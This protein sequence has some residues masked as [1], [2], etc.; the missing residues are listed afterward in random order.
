MSLQ[1]L[2]YFYDPVGNITSI[3]DANGHVTQFAYDAANHLTV[4]SYFDGTTVGYAYD[5][6]GNRTSMT[7]YRGTTSYIYDALNRVSGVAQ[8]GGATVA[9]SYD[10]VGHRVGVNYPDNKAV[11]Y[12]YDAANRLRN[13]TDW[14]NR[15]TAYS[16][17]PANRLLGV[18]Y[19]NT[20]SISFAYD[21]ANRL[22]NVRNTYPASA[23]GS[24][25]QF[26]SFTYAL[27]KV[28]NRTS[29]TD[30]N[31]TTT[32]YTFDPRYEL[33]S[34]T[35][36]LGSTNYT[37]DA[38]GNRL[39][40]SVP[41]GSVTSYKYDA[42]DRLLSAGKTSFTYDKNGNRVS[43]K[44]PGQTLTYAYD[45]ANRL[46]S[47]AGGSQPSTFAYDGDGHRV[48]QTIPS[49]TYT[50]VNDTISSLPVVLQE[51]GPDGFI[52]YAYGLGLISESSS[53]FDY[54][55]HVDGLGSTVGLTD[56]AGS[57]QQGY[58]YDAWGNIG[59]PAPNY[60]GTANKFRYTGQALD[61]GSFL[62]YLRARYL[63]QG[64]G[65]F[66][67]NDPIAHSARF[68]LAANRY[69]YALSN[70]VRYADATGLGWFDTVLDLSL[71]Y[72]TGQ[73]ALSDYQSEVQCALNT[74]TGC[75]LNDTSVNDTNQEQV[76]AL[77]YVRSGG[78]EA[79]ESIYNGT[80]VIGPG[81][82][83]TAFDLVVSALNANL[84]LK[85]ISSIPGKLIDLFTP[86]VA[87]AADLQT[88]D[89]SSAPS[90]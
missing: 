18:N 40:L 28:G 39:T 68:P 70:P 62:Y 79:G 55:Y 74:G 72:K 45:A 81:R 36:V 82:A 19:P 48:S 16:F 25:G 83:S 22:T 49:G 5:P 41:G 59:A 38:F 61:P 6:D 69:A 80:N 64:I 88:V 73:Q 75:T 15:T 30:G 56:S 17:D 66:I 26:T 34:A 63:E 29:V 4:V 67:N 77:N 9:Y 33:T 47:V 90:K 76:K 84:L 14:Q 58:T 24:T 86:G 60:V 1:D 53:A 65:R 32:S 12:S 71:G 54:F 52:S 42:D 46:V 20:A 7:D 57:L 21:S 51:N 31:G 44:T 35:N 37:Y 43:Q 13:V 27:D 8:P 11:S 10:A 89:Q 50:Y 87:K 2:L 85:D 23:I 3:T 78:I